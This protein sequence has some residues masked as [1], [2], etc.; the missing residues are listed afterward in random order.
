MNCYH[1]NP[2]KENRTIWLAWVNA[3]LDELCL[4]IYRRNAGWLE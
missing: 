4:K 1:Y 2:E 3:I